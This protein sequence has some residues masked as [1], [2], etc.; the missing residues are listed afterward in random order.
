MS[1]VVFCCLT[2][3]YVKIITSLALRTRKTSVSQSRK[4]RRSWAGTDPPLLRVLVSVPLTFFPQNRHHVRSVCVT[5]TSVPQQAKPQ[6]C[7]RS[8]F[9]DLDH[10]VPHSQP[11]SIHPPGRYSPSCFCQ[12]SWAPSSLALLSLDPRHQTR[13]SCVSAHFRVCCYFSPYT[14]EGNNAILI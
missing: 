9:L 8:S 1:A 4:Q 5:P 11:A 14:K 6:F 10:V 13:L 12:L 7:K 2:S 3:L